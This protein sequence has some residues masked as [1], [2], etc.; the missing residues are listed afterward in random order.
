MQI[1]RCF[2]YGRLVWLGMV[3]GLSNQC[4]PVFSLF[5]SAGL[6]ADLCPAIQSLGD[7]W[8]LNRIICSLCSVVEFV[9]KFGFCAPPTRIFI[10]FPT[11]LA[12]HPKK[13]VFELFW[14]GPAIG[15]LSV[16]LPLRCFPLV[17]QLCFALRS[18][19]HLIVATSSA[20]HLIVDASSCF[21]FNS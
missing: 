17:S 18:C 7:G 12:D 3:V 2:G 8:S 15:W 11:F 5:F 6:T 9:F 19:F 13:L 10:Q 1:L 4:P 21:Q 20:F 16:N 14:Y